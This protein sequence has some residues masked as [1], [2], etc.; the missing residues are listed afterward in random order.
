MSNA[1]L[2]AFV[3]FI[4]L[5]SNVTLLYSTIPEPTASTKFFA[6]PF[7]LFPTNLVPCNL[8]SPPTPDLINVASSRSVLLYVATFTL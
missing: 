7:N 5:F 4:S 1:V 2:S 3:L 6:R 8:T